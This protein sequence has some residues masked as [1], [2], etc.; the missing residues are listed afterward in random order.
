MSKIQ[1]QLSATA[2]PTAGFSVTE[3]GVR[4][5][6]RTRPPAAPPAV[7]PSPSNDDSPAANNQAKPAEPKSRDYAV[8]YGKPPVQTRFQK[9][10]SGNPKGRPKNSINVRTAIIKT[11][12]GTV[13][14]VENGRPVTMSRPEA[15]ARQ[16]Y[17]HAAKGNPKFFQMVV[18][19]A[20]QHE[21]QIEA[22]R[23]RRV[24]A[25]KVDPKDQEIIELFL[26]Q[27]GL[28][29]NAMSG[30]SDDDRTG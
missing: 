27:N 19:A 25:A 17:A 7:V 12:S 13:T 9:G 6:V 11:L 23:Q 18:E 8:G 1:T 28:S 30:G 10:K 29:K 21:A 22:T 24:E 20:D 2:A 26:K 16:A 5:R 3:G 14:V 4:F 15:L